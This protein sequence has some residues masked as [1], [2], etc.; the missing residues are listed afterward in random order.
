MSKE[1]QQTMNNENF[2]DAEKRI[3][4]LIRGLRPYDTLE[5]TLQKDNSSILQVICRN[6]VKETFPIERKEREY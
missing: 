3:I 5:I 6:T 1:D 4:L 2:T